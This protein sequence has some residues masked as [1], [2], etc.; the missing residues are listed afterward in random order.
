MLRQSSLAAAKG[1]CQLRNCAGAKPKA[2][3]A[4][5]PI[6]Q[7]RLAG[8]KGPQPA[9]ELALNKDPCPR[10]LNCRLRRGV[11]GRVKGRRSCAGAKP[12]AP[13]ANSATARGV[14]R[15]VKSCCRGREI[16]SSLR[17]SSLVVS[18]GHS[19]LRNSR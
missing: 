14:R 3:H 12:K 8:R 17:Q 15:G 6:A 7:G 9:A 13:R 10:A 2:T 16:C 1:R 18:I 11:R 5:L 19:Q 4:E